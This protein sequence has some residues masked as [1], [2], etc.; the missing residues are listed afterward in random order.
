MRCLAALWIACFTDIFFA[1]RNVSKYVNV[2]FHAITLPRRFRAEHRK[3]ERSLKVFLRSGWAVLCWDFHPTALFCASTY[4][5]S[6]RGSE[7]RCTSLLWLRHALEEAKR[8]F[9]TSS[10][11]SLLS[12]KCVAITSQLCYNLFTT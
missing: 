12:L 10:K 3:T 6:I 11:N 4:S 5:L 8:M 7:L 2:L 1:S 9:H